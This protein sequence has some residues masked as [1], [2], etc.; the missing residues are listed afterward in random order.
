MKSSLLTSGY[1]RCE[2]LHVTYVTV[3]LPLRNK[4]I[5]GVVRF[6]FA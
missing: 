3:D 2:R 6:V 1:R 4:A 5:A